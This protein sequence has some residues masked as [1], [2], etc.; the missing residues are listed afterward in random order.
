MRVKEV[1]EKTG[2]TPDTVRYYEKTGLLPRPPRSTSGYRHFE[3]EHVERIRFIK[4]AQRMGLRLGDIKELLEIRDKGLCPC[5]H[6]VSA[7]QRRIEQI[8]R[9]LGEL[10]KLRRQLVGMST[11]LTPEAN[12]DASGKWPCEKKFGDLARKQR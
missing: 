11:R 12:R 2:I 6:T 1:A 4:G 5:G 8:D 9:D 3:P 10:R 7:L